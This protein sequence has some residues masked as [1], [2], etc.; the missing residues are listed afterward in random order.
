MK[1]RVDLV[2]FFLFF[3][4]NLVRN[5][6]FIKFEKLKKNQDDLG[7]VKINQDRFF[8]LKSGNLVNPEM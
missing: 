2:Y 5:K 6:V 4:T 1:E 3:I 7:L 8:D